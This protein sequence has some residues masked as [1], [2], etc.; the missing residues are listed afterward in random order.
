MF[1]TLETPGGR[2]LE[3]LPYDSVKVKWLSLPLEG[4]VCRFLSEYVTVQ[5]HAIQVFNP[6]SGLEVS[7]ISDQS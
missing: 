5:L 7:R 1:S 2:K 4:D 3:K 6:A